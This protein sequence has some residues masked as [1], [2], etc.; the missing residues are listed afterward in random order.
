MANRFAL[1]MCSIAAVSVISKISRSGGTPVL[2]RSRSS[3][4]STSGWFS[5]RAEMLTAIRACEWNPALAIV[6]IARLITQR[7]IDTDM[8]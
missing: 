3:S 7:S 6:S 2:A 8:P 1:A 4:S 5:V